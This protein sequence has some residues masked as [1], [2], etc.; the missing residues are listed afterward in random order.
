MEKGSSLS[1][2]EVIPNRPLTE[3]IFGIMS[4][5]KQ[6]S[7]SMIQFYIS[8][9]ST[10]LNNHCIVVLP[11]N[12]PLLT[13]S[14]FCETFFSTDKV[15]PSLLNGQPISS[16][17]SSSSQGILH[18]MKMRSPYDYTE[19]V[20]SLAATGASCILH[21]SN[22]P[23][24]YAGHPFVPVFRISEREGVNADGFVNEGVD[25]VM[26]R[27][28]RVLSREDETIVCVN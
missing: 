6:L 20:T 12:D 26:K 21:Y 16:S 3:L 25:K 23:I 7:S 11:E 2:P 19:T 4:S 14:T 10:L 1:Q 27:I 24:V 13:H 9:C 22:I 5:E 8:L 18:V 17:S 15:L 28:I